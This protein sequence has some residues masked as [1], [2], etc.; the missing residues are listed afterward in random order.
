MDRKQA[1]ETIVFLETT[2][3]YYC[4]EGSKRQ[5]QYLAD[6]YQLRMQHEPPET[7]KPSRLAAMVK[8]NKHA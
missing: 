2:A 8:T 7:R 3:N 5:R 6:A 4:A 1:I